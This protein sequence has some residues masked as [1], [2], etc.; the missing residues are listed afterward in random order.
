MLDPSD[1]RLCCDEARSIIERAEEVVELLGQNGACEGHKLV[2]A[3]CIVALR[4]LSQLV[5]GHRTRLASEAQSNALD[6]ATMIK[7]PWWFILRSRSGRERQLSKV[8]T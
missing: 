6:A 4:R 1:A 3:Q 7:R 8:R 2:A 5:E